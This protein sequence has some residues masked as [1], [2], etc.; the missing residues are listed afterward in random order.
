MWIPDAEH[1]EDVEAA[2]EGPQRAVTVDFFDPNPGASAQLSTFGQLTRLLGDV[3]THR[4]V[5]W[6]HGKEPGEAPQL[7]ETELQVRKSQV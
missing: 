7:S 1:G 3:V 4:S 5:L 2:G 6:L